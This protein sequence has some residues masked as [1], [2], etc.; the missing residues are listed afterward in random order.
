MKHQEENINKK[1]VEKFMDAMGITYNIFHYRSYLSHGRKISC[2]Q[3]NIF[4]NEDEFPLEIYNCF[5]KIGNNFE[6]L[7]SNIGDLRKSVFIYLGEGAAETYFLERS[8]EF[9]KDNS[10]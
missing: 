7:E 6:F 3:I 8:V 9:L 2:V 1:S 5:K 10:D 4:Q